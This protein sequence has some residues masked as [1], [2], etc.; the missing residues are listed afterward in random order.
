MQRGRI[1]LIS[2]L[3]FS[4]FFV[5]LERA[6]ASNLSIEALPQ[7]VG[8]ALGISDP[9]LQASVGGLFLSAIMFL[10]LV[11][12]CM[13]IR[14]KAPAVILSVMCLLFFIMV[15]WIPLFV[16]LLVIFLIAGFFGRQVSRWFK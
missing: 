9:T 13:L 12:P 5:F 4:L 1:L 6:H 15:G 11:L 7:K 16:L 10:T 2:L 14:N 8:E 3:F